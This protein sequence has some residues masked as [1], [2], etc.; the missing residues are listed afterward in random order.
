MCP[1]FMLY[2]WR[3]DAAAPD[4]DDPDDHHHRGNAPSR[5]ATLRHA[6]LG[7]LQKPPPEFAKAIE[8]HMKLRRAKILSQSEWIQEAESKGAT[9]HREVLAALLEKIKPLLEKIGQ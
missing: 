2:V 5:E 6:V 8:G 3:G 7:H 9:Q 1:C 4:L